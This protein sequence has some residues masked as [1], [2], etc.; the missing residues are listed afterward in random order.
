VWPAVPPPLAIFLAIVAVFKVK[1]KLNTEWHCGIVMRM[2]L[3][4]SRTSRDCLP[5]IARKSVREEFFIDNLLVRIHR[6]LVD[7]PR[8]MGV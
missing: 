5:E 4:R 8:A 2:L 1:Q 7:R 3:P 6:C